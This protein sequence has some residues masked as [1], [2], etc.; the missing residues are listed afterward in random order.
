MIRL[1]KEESAKHWLSVAEDGANEETS[2][3]MEDIR[4]QILRDESMTI[5]SPAG[6]NEQTKRIQDTTEKVDAGTNT[7]CTQLDNIAATIIKTHEE[8][9]SM[10]PQ[11]VETLFVCLFVWFLTT[12]QPLWVISVRRY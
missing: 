12:H 7:E 2:S 11:M 1:S 4:G 9:R 5:P 10:N 8:V 6:D 3:D